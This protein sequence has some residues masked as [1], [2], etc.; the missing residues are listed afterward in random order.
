MM[1]FHLA[2]FLGEKNIP[3]VHNNPKSQKAYRT[4]RPTE[5]ELNA[6]K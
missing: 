1:L 6:L 5:W 3:Q 2:M 4:L